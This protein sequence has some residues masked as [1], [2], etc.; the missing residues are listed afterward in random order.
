MFDNWPP[1]TY[2]QFLLPDGIAS[3]ILG[4]GTANGIDLSG[5][6]AG[7]RALARHEMRCTQFRVYWIIPYRAYWSLG[8]R[9]V[10][11]EPRT[12]GQL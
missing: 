1:I 10:T 2:K 5:H 11:N 4:R 3:L 7:L 12:D 8:L 6:C 9:L